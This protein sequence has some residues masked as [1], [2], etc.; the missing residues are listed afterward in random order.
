MAEVRVSGWGMHYVHECGQKSIKTC[1]C[2]S[3]CGRLVCLTEQVHY[4]YV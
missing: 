4:M 1:V 3:E 2:V